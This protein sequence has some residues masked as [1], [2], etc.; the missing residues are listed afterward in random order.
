MIVQVE[1]L[2]AITVQEGSSQ[3]HRPFGTMALGAKL[4]VMV[5]TSPPHL[6]LL[7]AQGLMRR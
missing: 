5:I 1:A 3:V 2:L 4:I 6:L 7:S